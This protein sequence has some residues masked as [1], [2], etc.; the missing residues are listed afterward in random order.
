MLLQDTQHDELTSNTVQALVVVVAPTCGPSCGDGDVNVAAG[1]R[2]VP[3]C[4]GGR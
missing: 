1:L 3:V 4:A 2:A